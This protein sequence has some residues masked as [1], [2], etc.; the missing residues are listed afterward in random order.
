MRPVPTPR[1]LVWD[2]PT[3]I[4][5]WTLAL[6]F[7]GAFLTADSE[8]WRDIH[9]LFGYS[10]L[11]LIAFR[12]VWG[13]SGTCY[14][15]FA[16][17]VRCSTH[18]IRYLAQVAKGQAWH[19]VGH[20]PVNAIAI[21]LLLLLGI[22]SGISGW[23]VYEEIGGDGLEELHEFTSN[24]MLAVVFVH[25]AG[26]LAVSYLQRENLIVAMITGRKR[27]AANRAISRSYPLVAVL[28]LTA[29]IGFWIWGL[30]GFKG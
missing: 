22:A 10:V 12:L 9:V 15:R 1:I 27:R 28:L 18:V 14:V 16:A 19:P 5:H 20:N 17:L 13:F 6:S 25:I 4:F 21:L 30:A 2:L 3:R 7:V 8:R 11:A 24:A 29:F 23:A 26:V